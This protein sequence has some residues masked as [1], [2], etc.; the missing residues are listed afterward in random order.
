MEESSIKKEESIIEIKNENKIEF[1][2]KKYLNPESDDIDIW[3]LP[4]IL[5]NLT[6]LQLNQNAIKDVYL[7]GCDIEEENH[8]SDE[9]NPVHL[10]R[11]A[12]KMKCFQD[13]IKKYVPD[14]YISGLILMGRPKKDKKKFKFYLK[15]GEQNDI[16]K[17]LP[18]DS[19]SIEDKIYKFKFKRKEN[20]LSKMKEGKTGEVQCVANYLN[21]CLGKILKKCGYTKDR[22]SRKILYYNKKHVQN[23]NNLKNSD[24]LFFPGLKAVCE[25]YDEGKIYMKLLPKRLLKSN[26]TYADYFYSLGGPNLEEN[27][28]LLKEKVVKKRGI[29]VYDQTV[30]KIDDVIFDN[31]YNITFKDKTNKEWTVGDYYTNH[32]NIK[33]NKDKIPIAVRIIDKGGK[34]QGSDRLF[35]HIPCFL[36]EAIGNIFG[37]KVDIKDLVQYPQ[38]KFEEINFIRNLIQENASQANEDELHNYLGNKFEPLT[39]D[40]QVIKPP[41]IYFD[42]NY[43]V[44]TK[45]SNINFMGTK[46]YSKIKELNKVDVYLLSLKGEAGEIIWDKLRGA[47]AELGI[48]F[49]EPPMYYPLEEYNDPD[50]FEHYIMDYFN[51]Q[52]EYYSDKKNKTDFIFMFMNSGKKNSFYYKIFKKVMNKYNWAIPTQVILYDERK[53][54][55]SNLSQ[56]TNILCQMWA[57]K[58]NELY[59]CDFGFVPKT[60]VVAYSSTEISGNRVLTSIAVSLG[61]KLYEYMFYSDIAEN[62]KRERKISPSIKDLLSNALKTIGKHVK[63]KIENIVIYRD[64]VNDKQMK[65]VQQ[66]EIG[67]IQKAIKEANDGIENKIFEE[68][69]WCLILVSK[70]N[71]VKMFLRNDNGGNNEI[72]INNIPV[73]TLVD[74]VITSNDKYDFYLNS[75]ESRQGTCSSTHYTVLYDNTQLDAFKIYKLTYYLTYLSYNTTK[76]IRVPAPLYFVTRRNKFTVEN[77]REEVINGKC[78]TL[79]ISL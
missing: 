75:A 67:F 22:S 36:L 29:K 61:N 14:Y 52:D 21:I 4:Q 57:K 16:L 34:L 17:E 76:S 18:E 35:I 39:V 31:P 11:I 2:P 23:A 12:R 20:D 38:E 30:I 68:T 62:P 51:K 64:A 66:Y 19:K 56:F 46:P 42:N 48:T 5:T 13:Q 9:F 53:M 40:G 59:I 10:M 78:R 37:D 49:K 32:L 44:E 79:N 6:A 33:L 71:E 8:I 77:L 60:M 55:K 1:P 58:G 26:Y 74:R 63:K 43:T 72:Q 65:F 54:K 25:T 50:D 27:L 47:S 70:L 41:L 45:N 15:V 69:K 3:T 7:Y 73:G 24:L 28:E